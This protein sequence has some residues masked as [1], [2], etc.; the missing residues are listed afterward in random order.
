MDQANAFAQA[1]ADRFGQ[2]VLPVVAPLMATEFLSPPPPQ[3]AFAAV[4]FTSAHGVTGAARLQIPLPKRAYC[5]GRATADAAAR[6]GFDAKSADGDAAALAKV[7]L[8]DPPAGPLLYL[9]GVD[10]AGDLDKLLISYNLR[11]LS[12]QVYLQKAIQF[13]GEPLDLLGRLGPLIVP[14][15]SPRS[16]RLFRLALPVETRA[17]LRLAVMSDAVAAEASAVPHETLTVAARPDV[18]A[19]LD[20]VE[21]LLAPPPAP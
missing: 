19:M 10:T 5:V 4:I 20:A 2:R 1:L 14:L 15:F 21:G 17:S 8:S 9:R 7:I 11:V 3:G 18:P 13:E 12:L 6:A 16:A